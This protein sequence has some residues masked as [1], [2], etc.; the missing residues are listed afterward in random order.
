[1]KEV[2]RPRAHVDSNGTVFVGYPLTYTT[3]ASIA[4]NSTITAE[5]MWVI[6]AV[7]TLFFFLFFFLFISVR[8]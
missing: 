3:Y 6:S 5:Y 2:V 1:M 4:S 7:F 8:R